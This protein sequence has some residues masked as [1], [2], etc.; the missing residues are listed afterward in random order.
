MEVD[1]TIWW[2]PSLWH[3]VTPLEKLWLHLWLTCQVGHKLSS[4]KLSKPN[5]MNKIIHY[6]T[7]LQIKALHLLHVR[8]LISYARS[9]QYIIF[10]QQKNRNDTSQ[11]FLGRGYGYQIPTCS[12]PFP[13]GTRALFIALAHPFL[14]PHFKFWEL[15]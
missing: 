3:S 9:S 11:H 15:S 8:P 10:W 5:N 2:V 1:M 6:H 4:S 13:V 7:D 12:P 14:H